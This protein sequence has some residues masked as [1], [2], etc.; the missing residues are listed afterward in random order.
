MEE[1][2]KKLEAEINKRKDRFNKNE[3]EYREQIKYLERELRI[4]YRQEPNAKEANTKI[5]DDLKDM[6]WDN[7]DQ[8]MPQIEELK[9]EQMKEL[10]RKYK[11]KESR[12]KKSIEKEKAKTG[13]KDAEEKERETE[14]RHHLDLI[15]NIATRINKE[16]NDLVVKNQQL[17][18][19][20]NDQEKEREL[21]VKQ[22]VK[23]KKEIGKTKEEIGDFKKTLKE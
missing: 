19:D 12:N 18:R 22:L 21:L 4:R 20:F 3:M 1:E 11:I 23:Q 8:F 6:I 7:I 13:D 17:K 5:T 2:N 15:T 14:L 16:N 9:T 10:S